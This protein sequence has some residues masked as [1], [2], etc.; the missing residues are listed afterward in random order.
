MKKYSLTPI[1]TM[2]SY[3]LDRAICFIKSFTKTCISFSNTGPVVNY[4][5]SSDMRS[6]DE[7]ITSRQR[8]RDTTTTKNQNG[9]KKLRENLTVKSVN[10]AFVRGLNSS[11]WFFI[12][13]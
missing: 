6:L 7:N 12:R 11:A 2:T 13:A 1:D 3:L 9:V 8:I 10:R 4:A 5:L